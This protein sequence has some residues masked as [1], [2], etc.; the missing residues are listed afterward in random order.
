MP[1]RTDIKRQM[2]A[3]GLVRVQRRQFDDWYV[4]RGYFGYNVVIVQ[5]GVGFIYSATRL[6]RKLTRTLGA[7]HRR[8]PSRDGADLIETESRGF[9]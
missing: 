3:A 2:K 6:F 5:F 1:K 7:I 8:K 4:H 9:R